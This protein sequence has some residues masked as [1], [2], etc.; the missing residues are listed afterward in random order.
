M[1]LRLKIPHGTGLAALRPLAPLFLIYVL[2]FVNVAIYW[3]N[4]HHPLRVVEWVNGE[5]L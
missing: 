1:V 2:S 5:S 4:H 3:S